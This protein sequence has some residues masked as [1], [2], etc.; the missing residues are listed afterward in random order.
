MNDAVRAKL[1]R[2][3]ELVET[4]R[5]AEAELEGLFGGVA[6]PPM[7]AVKGKAEKKAE[8]G[9]GRGKGNRACGLCRK[10]G[11]TARTCSKNTPEAYGF[12]A[13]DR[14]DTT[15]DSPLPDDHEEDLAE[16]IREEWAEGGRSSIDIC[17][18]L[19]ISLSQFNRIVEKYKIVR[20]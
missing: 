10:P 5:A 9:I 19:A 4:I 11:H 2:A 20:P 15:N 16:A 12:K 17:K 14:P 7:P 8:A 3:N 6:T 13:D 1:D 18:E